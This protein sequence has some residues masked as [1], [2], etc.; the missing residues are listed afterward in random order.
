MIKCILS[1]ILGGSIGLVLGSLFNVAKES[2]E[3][4]KRFK[5]N[6]R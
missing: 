1:F 2:E 6:K 3:N 4:A 5:S